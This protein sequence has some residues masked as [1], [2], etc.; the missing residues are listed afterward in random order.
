[1]STNDH[2]T[3]T[4]MWERVDKLPDNG[5]GSRFHLASESAWLIANDYR[6]ARECD[7]TILDE[8]E[9]GLTF[10][11]IVRACLTDAAK[12]AI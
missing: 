12:I 6:R 9:Q 2:P 5:E 7:P 4:A 3:I 10:E 8:F 11:Q 1:M